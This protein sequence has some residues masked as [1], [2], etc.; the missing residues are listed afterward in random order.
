MNFFFFLRT[1]CDESDFGNALELG[2]DLF[3]FGV[4]ELHS[5]A[6]QLLVTG[7]KMVK[8]PQF[9][10]IIK[11]HLEKRIK[12]ISGLSILDFAEPLQKLDSTKLDVSK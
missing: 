10:A 3:C 11:A 4:P 1:A 2:I 6:L 5:D 7:Y 8:K 9:I 12:G